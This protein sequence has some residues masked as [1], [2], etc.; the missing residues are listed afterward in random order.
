MASLNG[1]L[2]AQ[3][4][5]MALGLGKKAAKEQDCFTIQLSANIDSMRFYEQA[6]FQAIDS[7]YQLHNQWHRQM[8]IKLK[9]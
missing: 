9:P 6:G 3:K 8:K 2:G 7:A 4:M 5:V 1:Q